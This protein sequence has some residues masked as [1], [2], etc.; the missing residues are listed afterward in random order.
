MVLIVSDEHRKMI[1]DERNPCSS[2]RCRNTA[3]ERDQRKESFIFP[4]NLG[5]IT[6]FDCNGRYIGRVRKV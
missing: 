6:Q 2:L 5:A 3:G 1:N 4:E